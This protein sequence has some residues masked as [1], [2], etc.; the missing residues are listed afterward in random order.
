MWIIEAARTIEI[1]GK[2]ENNS[3]NDKRAAEIYGTEIYGK[4]ENNSDNDKRAVEI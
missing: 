1:Y 4:E 3:D 2:E